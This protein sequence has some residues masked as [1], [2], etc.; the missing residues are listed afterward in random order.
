[1]TQLDPQILQRISAKAE[2]V[3]DAASG[4]SRRIEQF[5][6]YLAHIPGKVET[7]YEDDILLLHFHRKGGGWTITVV[8]KEHNT[9]NELVS[10]SL[11]TKMKAMKMFPDLLFAMTESQDALINRLDQVSAEFDEFFQELKCRNVPR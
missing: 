8:D 6:D 2:V 9:T 1:M 5:V 7:M 3:R 4:L 11:K 10:A